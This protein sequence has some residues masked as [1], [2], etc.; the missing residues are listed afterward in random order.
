MISTSS[1][2]MFGEG[3]LER[4]AT[5]TRRGQRYV[6]WLGPAG[7]DQHAFPKHVV[8]RFEII[9]SCAPDTTLN[10]AALTGAVRIPSIGKH[11]RRRFLST[12]Y[13]W[14][15]INGRTSTSLPIRAGSRSQLRRASGRHLQ[16]QRLYSRPCRTSPVSLRRF[17][18]RL[19]VPG[20]RSIVPAA[21]GWGPIALSDQTRRL[22]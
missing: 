11:C 20:R 16:R 4:A 1:H 5:L 7:A 17:L 2:H 3:V 10:V 9:N 19:S 15:Q 12:Q 8:A 22:G 21:A 13:Q 6:L 18:T 14:N